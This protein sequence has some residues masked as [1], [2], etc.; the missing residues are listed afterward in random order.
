MDVHASCQK[1]LRSISNAIP[2]L[3][4]PR[5]ARLRKAYQYDAVRAHGATRRG[6]LFRLSCF[7]SSATS[8][9]N[10]HFS[11]TVCG[12][13]VSRRVGDAVTRNQVKRLLRELYRHERSS[14]KTALWIVLVA[15]PQAATATMAE[16][17]TE[18]ISLGKKL[19]IFQDSL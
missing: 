12:I 7:S 15:T 3:K 6:A 9:N 19:S 10:F 14:L 4:L 5:T 2:K 18:W 8:T 13:I 1:V 17:R 16:L 11:E